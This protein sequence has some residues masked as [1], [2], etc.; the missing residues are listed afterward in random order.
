MFPDGM[1]AVTNVTGPPIAH[2]RYWASDNVYAQQNGGDWPWLIEGELSLPLTQAFWD[3]L[4]ASS[5]NWGLR[6]YEQDWLDTV[7]DGMPSLTS[8]VTLGANWLRQMHHGAAKQGI[9]IQYCMSMVRHILQ[10]V[11]LPAVTQ[12]RA[13]GD[14]HS[15]LSDQ[16]KIGGSSILADAIGIY[17]SK[18]NAWSTA[19]QP[20]N[21]YEGSRTEPFSR[22]QF[23]VLSFSRGPVAGSDGIGMSDASLI[24]RSCTREGRLLRPDRPM[25]LM[26]GAI[27]SSALGASASPINGETWSTYT[28]VGGA[29]YP[30]VLAIEVQTA[31]TLA[32]ADLGLD[33]A[34]AYIVWEANDTTVQPFSA[35]SP[36]AVAPN[37]KASFAL[38]HVS[39]VGQASGWALVG[40]MD[41]WVATSADRFAD[42]EDSPMGLNVELKGDSGETVRVGFAK[43]GGRAI[44]T[45][46]CTIGPS[47]RISIAMPA[48]KCINL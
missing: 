7:V 20:G 8:N 28:T 47:G 5:R 48:A 39:P 24:L 43:A 9:T 6:T 40:E 18:D 4:M 45:V 33:P 34:G 3:W 1:T 38:L 23:A 2:N 13:S 46:A 37:T 10:S 11:E 27:A 15:N 22:L 19:S 16:W 17:P 32:P 14:Y 21:P 26:D 29:T 36:V 42:A 12:A 30:H 35:A 41:K 25:R 44:T 31:F